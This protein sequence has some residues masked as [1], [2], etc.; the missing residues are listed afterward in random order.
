MADGFIEDELRN[1]LEPAAADALAQWAAVHERRYG[2]DRWLVNGR[3]RAQVALVRETD[4]HR[5]RSRRLLM[6]VA[7]AGEETFDAIEYTRH[8]N[9]IKDAEAFAARHLSVPVH[10]PIRVD[11]TTWITFQTIAG[12]TF[13]DMQVLTTLLRR[14][15]DRAPAAPGWPAYPPQAVVD[16]CVEVVRAVLADW[17]QDV[18]LPLDE[19]PLTVAEFLGLHLRGQFEPGGRLYAAAQVHQ[20]EEIVLEGERGPLP[21][22]FAAAQGGYFGDTASIGPLR[23]RCHGDLHTDNALVRAGSVLAAGEFYLIDNALYSAHGP[24]T[25]DPVHLVLYVAARTLD[26]VSDAQKDALIDLLLDPRSGPALLVPGWLA[27]LVTGVDRAA[28]AWIEP[29]GLAREWRE[30]TLLSLAACSLMFIGRTSVR[31]ADKAWYLRLAAR[32][33]K[34]FADRNPASRRTGP[35]AAGGRA[36]RTAWIA[37]LCRDLPEAARAAAAQEGGDLAEE[38][39]ELR[40]AALSGLDR[41]GQYREFVRTLGGPDPDSRYGTRGT[42]GQPEPGEVF[43][44]PLEVCGRS[45][46]REP[47][48]ALPA[49]HLPRAGAK[50]LRRTLR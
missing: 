50:P 36:P 46:R 40:G 19:K 20:G 24:L 23:G 3:S 27:A 43:V 22:P 28:S 12:E 37:W 21:N 6:K 16:S 44:C 31:E 35:P 10:E 34:E 25:R 45:E 38:L 49:C 41:T 4:E 39:E 15:L 9:A 33:L 5:R 17:A 14:M 13:D 7:S 1:G 18:Y 32:A 2:F 26:T 29:S 11:D 30:Q 8:R 47:G 48:G 42:E